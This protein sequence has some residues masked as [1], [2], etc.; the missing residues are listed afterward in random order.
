MIPRAVKPQRMVELHPPPPMSEPR[1]A[2]RARKSS[3]GSVK[4]LVKTFE[5]MEGH[6]VKKPELKRV[7]SNGDWKVSSGKPG[8]KP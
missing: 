8:W 6:A 1:V 5:E 7:R 2:P 3:T 4:D